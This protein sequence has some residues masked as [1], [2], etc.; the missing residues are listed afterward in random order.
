MSRRSSSA[1]G[2]FAGLLLLALL[3][4]LLTCGKTKEP[5][6]S[7]STP[8]ASGAAPA[9]LPSCPPVDQAVR[10]P[11][12]ITRLATQQSY[13]SALAVDAN[14]VFW[15]RDVDDR[16]STVT[17]LA[18]GAGP[19]V[20]IADK[21]GHPGG[22]SLDSTNVYWYSG[23]EVFAVARTGGKPQLISGTNDYVKGLAAD[24]SGA[25]WVDGTLLMR[26]PPGW[27]SAVRVAEIP[28][29]QSL[30]LNRE[31]VFVGTLSGLYRVVKANNVAV[32]ILDGEIAL[33]AVDATD[34]YWSDGVYLHRA[35]LT[36]GAS[37]P[38]GP[39]HMCGRISGLALAAKSVFMTCVRISRQQ[40]DDSG[41]VVEL[42]KEGGCPTSVANKLH[43]PEGIAVLDG[44][45]YWTD[46]F[47][48]TV[49]RLVP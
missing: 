28:N 35:S 15:V 24:E 25:Y 37:V 32:R 13:A 30:A 44:A 40:R 3:G 48:G 41:N 8:G 19:P 17:R 22:L 29:A 49:S 36:G 11:R 7:V 31:Y 14:G 46:R 45:V 47:A 1:G 21:L 34:I 6:T 43:W 26:R 16:T 4:K 38:L 18:R 33:V 9:S 2:L 12:E 20:V 10:V 27:S 42:P 23:R 5:P 39:D